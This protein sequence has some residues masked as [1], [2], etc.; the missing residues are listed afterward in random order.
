[1]NFV[2]ICVCVCKLKSLL[3]ILIENNEG[4]AEDDLEYDALVGVSN[5]LFTITEYTIFINSFFYLFII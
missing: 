4:G 1:M 2:Y 3:L 5:F